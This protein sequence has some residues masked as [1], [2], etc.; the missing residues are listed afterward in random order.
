MKRIFPIITILI[1]L[2]LLGLIFFQ[3]LWIKSAREAKD[4]QVEEN[5]KQ[6]MDY[7]A[8]ALSQ[9]N[10]SIVPFGKKNDMLFPGEKLQYFKPS[11]MQ[12]YS[13]DDIQEIIRAAF[14]KSN[15]KNYPFEFAIVENSI[16]GKQL[17]SDNFYNLY[18]DSTNNINH[19]YPLQPPSGSN[20][21]NLVAEELLNVIVPNQKTIIWKEMFW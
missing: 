6:A 3:F 12:R 15:L 9:D 5:I 21:E 11:V 13:K 4:K 18:L 10:N 16:S 17:L 19:V 8:E 1:F 7:A 2:S 20:Y 14:N